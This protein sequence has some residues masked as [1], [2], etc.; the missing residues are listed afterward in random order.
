MRYFRTTIVKSEMKLRYMGNCSIYRSI[1]KDKKFHSVE[2]ETSAS[3]WQTVKK[4]N[5]PDGPKSTPSSSFLDMQRTLLLNVYH[6][7]VPKNTTKDTHKTRKSCFPRLETKNPFF[8]KVSYA[9]KQLS[10]QKTTCSQA[11]IRCES[12]RAPFDQ[13][14]V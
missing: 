10:A 9:E 1:E 8:G 7:S 3:V 6:F 2:Y 13:M 12:G 5:K 14:K 11:K 4:T